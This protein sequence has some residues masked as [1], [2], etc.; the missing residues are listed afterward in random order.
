MELNP[1][2][3]TVFSYLV[4]IPISVVGGA[5]LATLE[6]GLGDAYTAEVKEVFTKMWEV[7]ATTMQTKC[8][9]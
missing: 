1:S 4:T 3:S 6:Q 2:L 5:L 7:V 9:K 8:A